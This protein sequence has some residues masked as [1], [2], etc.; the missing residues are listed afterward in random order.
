MCDKL[1]AS[2]Q[3]CFELRRRLDI[4]QAE[5]MTLQHSHNVAI[6]TLRQ[7]LKQQQLLM[8][9]YGAALPQSSP[10]PGSFTDIS[11]PV[12]VVEQQPE[13]GEM[14]EQASNTVSTLPLHTVLAALLASPEKLSIQ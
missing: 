14:P 12:N 10:M 11:T 3:V 2:Q 7:Q 13:K 8:G 5:L 1:K 6:D 4:T 9:L